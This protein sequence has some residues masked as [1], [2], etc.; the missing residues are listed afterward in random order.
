MP[1]GAPAED[2]DGEPADVIAEVAGPTHAS[3]SP[4]DDEAAE[5]MIEAADEAFPPPLPSSGAVPPPSG[6]SVPP[7]DES[8]A[9][10]GDTAPADGGDEADR[11]PAAPARRPSRRKGGKA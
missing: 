9:S 4:V 8:P 5:A 6:A 7:P 10:S 1:A 3:D 11:P 2:D